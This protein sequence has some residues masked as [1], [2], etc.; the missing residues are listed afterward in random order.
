MAGWSF[1]SDFNRNLL[2][3]PWSLA[4]YSEISHFEHFVLMLG[5]SGIMHNAGS[6][7]FASRERCKLSNIPRLSRFERLRPALVTNL[8]CQA[9]EKRTMRESE[10]RIGN[11]GP[12]IHDG[13][14]SKDGG[15]VRGTPQDEPE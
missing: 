4:L 15:P 12:V 2:F 6:P 3:S 8:L 11:S 9:R 7:V 10:V 13:G 14:I 1:I 5:T